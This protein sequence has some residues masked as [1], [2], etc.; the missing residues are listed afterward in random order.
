MEMIKVSVNKHIQLLNE[1]VKKDRRYEEG[2][3]VRKEYLGY[4]IYFNGKPSSKREHNEMFFIARQAVNGKYIFDV[5][6][7]DEPT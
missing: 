1:E 5:W 4:N 6:L 2:I 3:E 7:T